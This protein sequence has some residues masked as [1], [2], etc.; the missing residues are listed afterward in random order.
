MALET[1]LETRSL[2][3]PH[4]P[5]LQ[6]CA[7]ILPTQDSGTNIP[8]AAWDQGR[9]EEATWGMAAVEEADTLR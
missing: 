7:A 6:V 1:S 9:R 5:H 8:M 4:L 3:L 2:R